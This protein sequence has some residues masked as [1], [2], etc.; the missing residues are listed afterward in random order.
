MPNFDVPLTTD[1]PNVGKRA[2]DAWRRIN[3][4]PSSVQFIRNGVAQTAQ[5]VRVEASNGGSE[6]AIAAG[7]TGQQMAVVYGV[8]DHPDAS[9]LDTDMERGDRFLYDG[10]MYLIKTVVNHNGEIQG[11]AEVES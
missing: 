8:K 7:I 2:V 10:A 3:H 1:A 6:I 5:T 11:F 9:V 4:R